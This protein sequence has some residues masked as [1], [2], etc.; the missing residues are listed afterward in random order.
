MKMYHSTSVE[1]YQSIISD[2]F[3]SAPV[4]LTPS[5]KI[6]EEYGANNSP[7]FVIIEVNVDEAGFCADAEFVKGQMEADQAI[8]ESL[9]NGSVFIDED[10]SVAGHIASHYEDYEEVGL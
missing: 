10:V 3:L 4:Y 5:K 1:N 8:E 7:E 2:G 9:S 6:A